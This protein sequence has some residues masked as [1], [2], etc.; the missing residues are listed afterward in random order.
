MESVPTPKKFWVHD[1]HVA[2]YATSFDATGSVHQTND[3]VACH[4]GVDG[5]DDRAAAHAGMQRMPGAAQCGQCHET[6]AALAEHSLH[7]AVAGMPPVLQQRGVSFADGSPARARFEAQCAKC[8]LAN[9]AGQTACGNCHVSVPPSAG[10]GFL[11]GHRFFR[12][13]STDN[14]CTA[15]H[16]SR[17][18]D[19]YY[20][21]NGALLARNAAVLP[22]DSPW[23]S[24]ALA[25]D[26]HKAKGMGCD[27]CH[28]PG[29]MHGVG[30]LPGVDRYGIEGTPQCLDCHGPGKS[31]AQAFAGVGFMHNATHL[32]KL[33]CQVCHAQPYK[34]C[35][36][37]HTDVDAK[38]TGFYRINETDPTR[39]PR[40][41]APPA[42]SAATTY[43]AGAYVT[44]NA[45]EYRSLKAGNV[46][47]LPDVAGSTWWV[48]GTA[49]LPAGDALMTFRIGKNPKAGISGKAYSVLRHVPVDPDVFRYS[50]AEEVDGLIPDMNAIPTW[51]HATPH[52]ISRKTPI[53]ASCYNCHGPDYARFWL[54]DA[55]DGAAGW[56]P[57][58]AANTFY[59]FEVDANV[60]VIQP[61][62]PPGL[63]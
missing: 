55:V 53:Q 32:G 39:G 41:A 16:G 8:H 13:P 63:Q 37:C 31:D 56:V 22:A 25:P 1:G 7:T 48:A 58:P 26:V 29:E 11:A 5:T 44:Y 61:T 36:G 47:N 45:L 49:P 28:S 14:N 15:C 38:G 18:K 10:G 57:D 30:A 4:G 2:Q 46:N 50:G 42:W 59:Q 23:K 21:L 12:T 62:V 54:T 35:F 19:E 43:A 20:G 33:D 34:N 9:T 24:Y 6:V 40:R 52:S 60:G 17:V 3:C 27:A 51:K